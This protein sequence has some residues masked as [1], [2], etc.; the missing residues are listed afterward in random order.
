M[1]C[2]HVAL[3]PVLVQEYSDTFELI[4]VEV[5]IAEKEIRVMTGYGPQETWDINERS[6]F[7]NTLEKEISSSELQGKS[8]I[9]AM[10]ANAKLGPGI[11]KGDPMLSPQMANY[12]K[13]LW[14]DMHCV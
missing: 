1:L 11:I 2:V 8:V 10:D 4:V 7:Y 3:Q 12:W 6:L 9:I 14:I 13:Q 5:K